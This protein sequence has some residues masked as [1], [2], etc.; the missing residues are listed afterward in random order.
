MAQSLSQLF[1]SLQER[2]NFDSYSKITDNMFVKYSCLKCKTLYKDSR[3][4]QITSKKTSTESGH[5]NEVNNSNVE[6]TDTDQVNEFT[7][8]DQVNVNEQRTNEMN[9]SNVE[10]TDT[11]Q[12]NVNEQRTK[13]VN[14]PNVKF[15][16]TNEV[17]VNKQRPKEVEPP[18]KGLFQNLGPDGSVPIINIDINDKSTNTNNHVK[19]P[20]AATVGLPLKKK[21]VRRNKITVQQTNKITQYLYM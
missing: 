2:M 4:A 18:K 7:D 20:A 14:R 11:D 6:I 19:R 17:N 3:S 12:V 13:K 21:R 9:K 15:T 5:E 8:T 1:N 10:F 16:D